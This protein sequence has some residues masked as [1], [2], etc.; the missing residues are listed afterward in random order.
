MTSIISGVGGGYQL[1]FSLC[2]VSY[3]RGE[4]PE[5]LHMAIAFQNGDSGSCGVLC[6]LDL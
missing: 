6:W 3:P 4:Y 5:F 1:S 2:V